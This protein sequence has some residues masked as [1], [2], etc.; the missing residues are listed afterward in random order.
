MIASKTSLSQTESIPDWT[1]WIWQQRNA[2]RTVDQL[3]EVFPGIPAEISNAIHQNEQTRRM[4]ITPYY[5]TLIQRMPGGRAPVDDDPM[6]RQ[7]V[8]YWDG[9]GEATY[10]YDG[11]TENWELPSEMVTPIAQR[12]YDNRVIVRLSNVCHAYCQFCYEAL[13]TRERQSHKPNFQQ[14]HWDATV[15]YL[16]DHDEIEEVILSGGEPLMHTDER[17][18]K[19]LADLRNIGRQ[20]AIRIHTRALTFNPFRITDDLLDIFRRHN[21]T[22]VGLH[23]THPNEVTEEFCAA[24]KRLSAVVPILF[25]NMPLLRGVNDNTET[26][27]DLGMRLYNI[28]VVPHYLYHFM[29]Y[30][31]GAE[32]FRTSVW[33][34]VE[35]IKNLKR[36]V[37]DLAV[38]EFVL[39]HQSGKHT[40]PLLGEDEAPPRR[41][42]DDAGQFVVHY[43]NWRGDEVDYFDVPIEPQKSTKSANH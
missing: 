6:W 7:V 3:L 23:V 42:L 8:P 21:L 12:K 36:H 43:T 9:E 33:T 28:G 40:M 5:L 22:S 38:P 41:M 11:E 29:P 10:Q 1:S 27:H 26:I 20:I 16:R 18:E 30:S 25:A 35:I 13:R 34:G 37:S 2:I 39:P 15:N 31:P 19:V 17:L 14:Q 32:Q 4:Q 24:V